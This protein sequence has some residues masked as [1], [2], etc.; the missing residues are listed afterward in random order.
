MNEP[1]RRTLR[2]RV[3]DRKRGIKRE[4]PLS[5]SQKRKLKFVT[6]AFVVVQYVGL[7]LLLIG[8]KDFV[9]DGFVIRNVNLFAISC[10]MFLIGRVG[11]LVIKT[12]NV[13]K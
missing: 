10:G 6:L 9:A 3:A 5:A 13:F 12:L 7:M 4:Q 2:Q 11:P 1:E 8:L